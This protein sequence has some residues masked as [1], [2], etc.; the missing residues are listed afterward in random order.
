MGYERA[1]LGKLLCDPEI[2]AREILPTSKYP[3]GFLS[4][5]DFTLELR[6]PWCFASFYFFASCFL[7]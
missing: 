2:L 6:Y 1:L 5:T 4:L 7:L 3:I